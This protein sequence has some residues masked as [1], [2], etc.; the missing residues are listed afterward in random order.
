MTL[1]SMS[2]QVL[3]R[4]SAIQMHLC[5]STCTVSGSGILIGSYV[6]PDFLAFGQDHIVCVLLSQLHY[7]PFR[8]PHLFFPWI[9]VLFVIHQQPVLLVIEHD[10][11]YCVIGARNSLI[12]SISSG[13]SSVLRFCY[14]L[15]YCH[16]CQLLG[17]LVRARVL[18]TMLTKNLLWL[19]IVSP[20]QP[21]HSDYTKGLGRL[22]ERICQW[23]FEW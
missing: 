8:K 17:I 3:R 13:V 9:S 15:P 12:N 23:F 19:L 16:F 18:H 22:L 21:N 11:M 6:C 7:Q 14:F 20:L 2:V 5:S 1:L 10:F 4:W